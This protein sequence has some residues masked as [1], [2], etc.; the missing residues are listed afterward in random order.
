MRPMTFPRSCAYAGLSNL[1]ADFGVETDDRQIVLELNLP[2]QLRCSNGVF[3]AGTMLQSPKWFNRYLMPRGL[4]FAQEQIPS[5]QLPS[6]LQRLERQCMLGIQI[7]NGHKHAVLYQPERADCFT[8]WNNAPADSGAPAYFSFTAEELA[9]RV[10][11]PVTVGYLI[12][13]SGS[14]TQRDPVL[15]CKH[16][17]ACLSKYWRAMCCVWGKPTASSALSEKLDPVFAAFFLDIPIMM[18]LIGQQKL[19]GEIISLRTRFLEALKQPEEI[20]LSEHISPY[21]L[22][23]AFIDYRSLLKERW[24]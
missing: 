13:F 10:D 19:A 21:E 12:P 15:D 23:Q 17:L 4:E 2:Y 9:E 8:L 20:C 1:L 14:F 7:E 5:E 24:L 3:Y 22:A 6:F 18:E 16:S 11:D